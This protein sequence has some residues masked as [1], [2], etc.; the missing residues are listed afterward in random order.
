MRMY[1]LQCFV[2]DR[3][4]A[5]TQHFLTKS[6]KK[7]S[8]KHQNRKHIT[9]KIKYVSECLLRLDVLRVF[10]LFCV[11]VFETHKNRM[12]LNVCC[13]MML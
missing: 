13:V 7:L 9:Q 5:V 2:I 4:K 3:D 1:V 6:F 12:F 8:I 11:F 10:M